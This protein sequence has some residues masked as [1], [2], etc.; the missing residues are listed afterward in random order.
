MDIRMGLELWG[1]IKLKKLGRTNDQKDEWT[2][3]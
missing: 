3:I 1:N 2:R